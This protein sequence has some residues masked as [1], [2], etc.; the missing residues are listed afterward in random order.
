MK[1]KVFSI[2]LEADMLEKDQMVLNEFLTTVTFKKSSTQFVEKGNYWS[3]LVHYDDNEITNPVSLERISFE[4]LST[5]DQQVYLYL[6][7]WR[8]T[9]AE[10][11][12]QKNYMICHNSELIDLARFKPSNLDELKQ[13]KGFGPQKAEKFGDDILAILNAV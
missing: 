11:L 6:K 2:G 1:V 12:Q 4:D 8:T 9:K 10:K 13:I 5:K 3:L 7:E